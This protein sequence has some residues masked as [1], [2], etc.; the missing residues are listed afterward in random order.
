ML[1]RAY[2]VGAHP[3]EREKCVIG[4][5]SALE[6]RHGQGGSNQRVMTKDV[7]NTGRLKVYTTTQCGDCTMAKGI[8]D[9]AGID[10][11]EIDIDL[12][13]AATATVLAINGG[14]RPVS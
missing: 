7:S 6:H 10:Y 5:T 9:K 1:P 2:A 4:C 3:G 8:L 14:Y 11:Q 12:D 13:P